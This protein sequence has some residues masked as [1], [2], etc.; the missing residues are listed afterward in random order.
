MMANWVPHNIE[1]TGT[2]S[3][4]EAR[5]PLSLPSLEDLELGLVLLS[6]PGVQSEVAL[7]AMTDEFDRLAGQLGWDPRMDLGGCFPVLL[8]RLGNP[9]NSSFGVTLELCREDSWLLRTL[10]EGGSAHRAT[11]SRAAADM[12]VAEATLLRA[13][14]RALIRELEEYGAAFGF[15]GLA[16]HD[17]GAAK[18][19]DLL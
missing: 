8:E 13:V 6:D 17:S 12:G 2:E 7:I 1:I 10:T 9:A 5:A 14:R 4:F 3:D 19:A 16:P 15:N 18:G 11:V